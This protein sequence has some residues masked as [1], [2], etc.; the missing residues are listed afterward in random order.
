LS[1]SVPDPVK[2]TSRCA[3]PSTAAILSRALSTAERAARPDACTDDG[4]P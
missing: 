3:H 4:F 2:T 1:A